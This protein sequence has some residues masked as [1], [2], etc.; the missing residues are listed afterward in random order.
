MVALIAAVLRLLAPNLEVM[1]LPLW[2]EEAGG[3]EG[4]GGVDDCRN[5]VGARKKE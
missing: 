5:G 4:D 1:L 3:R 2:Y